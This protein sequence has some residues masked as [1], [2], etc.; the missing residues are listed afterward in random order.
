MKA[1]PAEL[2][3]KGCNF[4]RKDINDAVNVII[5]PRNAG[6]RLSWKKTQE[7]SRS[8]LTCLEMPLMVPTSWQEPPKD[9]IKKDMTENLSQRKRGLCKQWISPNSL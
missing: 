7:T 4:S 1:S 8:A 9:D 2:V 6:T 5:L 3:L